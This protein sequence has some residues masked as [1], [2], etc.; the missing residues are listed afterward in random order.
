MPLVRLIYTSEN[1]IAVPGPRALIHFNDI[2]STARANNARHGVCGFLLF[3][4]RRFY[5][6][7]EG[8]EAA[9]DRLFQ[10]IAE[11]RRH[12]HVSVLARQTISTRVFA[13]WSM[14]SFLNDQAGSEIAT[15][16]GL[17]ASGEAP[18]D[19]QTFLQFALA[20]LAIDPDGF[21]D[22]ASVRQEDRR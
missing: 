10:T 6:A 15:S 14:A 9:V 3:D 17:P 8:P 19:A 20:Y 16:L 5:Q 1:A 2:V 18:L 11:D 22:A 13:D 7:L 4:R 12:R 21:P